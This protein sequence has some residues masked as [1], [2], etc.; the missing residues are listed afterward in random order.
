MPLYFAEDGAMK[1]LYE[2]SES[3]SM[4][5]SGW[6]VHVPGLLLHIYRDNPAIHP[7]FPRPLNLQDSM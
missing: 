6:L 3:H 2:T 1:S 7:F 5:L 4:V